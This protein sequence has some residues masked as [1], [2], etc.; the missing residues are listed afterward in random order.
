MDDDIKDSLLI[1]MKN[2][3]RKYEK[4]GYVENSSDEDSI[5]HHVDYLFNIINPYMNSG[6]SD[7]KFRSEILTSKPEKIRSCLWEAQLCGYLQKQNFPL[8]PTKDEGPDFCFV[9]D[10]GQ[11]FWIE[12]TTPKPMC[13]PQLKEIDRVIAY[14]LK[15]IP[16]IQF[17]LRW[18][19]AI[20]DKKE[21]FEKYIRKGIV[22]DTDI[23]IIA[24]SSI[25]MEE[26]HPFCF[27]ESSKDPTY[28]LRATYG[29]GRQCYLPES[30]TFT[31]LQECKINKKQE[32][33]VSTN[34]FYDHKYNHISAILAAKTSSYDNY[35]PEY[36]LI[37]NV[38]A[39]NKV[40][41][42]LFKVDEEWQALPLDNETYEI[43]LVR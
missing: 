40:P 5:K 13:V 37:H 26:H 4:D 41:T 35:P 25:G 7:R 33:T 15:F 30:G 43:T 9:G 14:P 16:R 3:A 18:T 22:K 1:Y 8:L 11:R 29:I 38:K 31:Y 17:E 28:A 36:V 2:E 12:A 20:K 6:L 32:V 24:I 10:H 34:V 23:C 27:K 39:K 21:A 42:K 19:S